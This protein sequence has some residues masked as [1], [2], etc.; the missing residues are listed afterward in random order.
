M[1]VSRACPQGLADRARDD[2]FGVQTAK[3][4]NASIAE[5]VG[6]ERHVGGDLA[7]ALE[8]RV[9]EKLINGGVRASRPRRLRRTMARGIE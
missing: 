9:F 3:A 7:S 5:R 1:T 4:K 8:A 2:S 6:C